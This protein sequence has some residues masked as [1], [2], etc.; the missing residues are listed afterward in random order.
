MLPLRYMLMTVNEQE[1]PFSY[2]IN[3]DMIG[4]REVQEGVLDTTTPMG[5]LMVTML[6]G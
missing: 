3:N 5:K 2:V 4:E 1:L 6:G